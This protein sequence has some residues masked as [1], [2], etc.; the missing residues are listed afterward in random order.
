MTRDQVEPR[1]CRTGAVA[2]ASCSGMVH[3]ILPGPTSY[4]TM[5]YVLYVPP[6]HWLIE[7]PS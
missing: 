4:Y 3:D 6:L 2:V 7:N 1:W 5:S